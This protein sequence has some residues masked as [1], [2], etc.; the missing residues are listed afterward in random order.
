MGILGELFD[1]VLDL[2]SKIIEKSVETVAGL[3]ANVIKGID[4]GIEKLDEED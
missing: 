4:K 2:P 1:D 3:P